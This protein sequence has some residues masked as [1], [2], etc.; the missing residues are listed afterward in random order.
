MKSKKDLLEGTAEM[1]GRFRQGR[2]DAD[3]KGYLKEGDKARLAGFEEMMSGINKSIGDICTEVS[4]LS[5]KTQSM[6]KE[7]QSEHKW[8]AVEWAAMKEVLS[9]KG[10]GSQSLS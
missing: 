1:L 10:Q 6:M 9:K 4:S 7:Y 5:N 8:M 2:A 3:I